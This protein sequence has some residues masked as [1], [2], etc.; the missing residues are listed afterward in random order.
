MKEMWE[1]GGGRVVGKGGNVMG[2]GGEVGKVVAREV[3]GGGRGAC[4]SPGFWNAS[5]SQNKEYPLFSESMDIFGE[6]FTSSLVERGEGGSGR[7]RGRGT[8]SLSMTLSPAPGGVVSGQKRKRAKKERGEDASVY[9]MPPSQG[10]RVKGGEERKVLGG[11]QQLEPQQQQQQQEQGG[12]PSEPRTPLPLEKR[13]R[14]G[15]KEGGAGG[16][17]VSDFVTP[18]KGENDFFFRTPYKTPERS[19]MGGKEK[20]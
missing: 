17:L 7:A 9:L 20:G 10:G 8:P 11:Q 15:E 6:P 13:A 1:K 19:G 18:R 2:R 14:L 3:V 16:L 12:G 5:P 4:G